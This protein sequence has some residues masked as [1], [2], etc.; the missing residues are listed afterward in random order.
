MPYK[1][2]NR[3]RAYGRDWISRNAEKARDA[4]RR[5]RQRHPEEH[6]AESRAFY[7]RHR[8]RIKLMRAAYHAANP[9]VRRT[10]SQRRRFREA[11]AAGS[12]T[13]KEWLA[14]L[15]A[16]DRQC[17]YCGASG[18]LHADHRVPLARGGTN[19]I[20]NII[21][22]CVTCNL[23]KAKLT[24][25]EFLARL[26]RERRIEESVFIAYPSLAVSDAGRAMSEQPR[27]FPYSSHH[28][29]GS[30]EA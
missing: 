8:E 11:N 9:E 1:D 2:P 28:R 13:T 26:R 16:F 23:R 4:M 19:F 20:G 10:A 30:S 17:G 3:R 21:P 5:W 18:P 15:D 22:A 7:A 25:E 29:L 6:N 14:L 12:Y 27:I 24:D